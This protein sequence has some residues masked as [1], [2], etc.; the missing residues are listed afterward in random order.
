MIRLF[1]KLIIYKLQYYLKFP[2]ALPVSYTFSI[3]NRCN[4]R[5]KTC[6]VYK[7]S[8]EQMSSQEYAEIFKSIG[9]SPFWVTIS[10]GEPFLRKDLPEIIS[11]LYRHCHPNV[12]NI[13]SNGILTQRI[14]QMVKQITQR[15]PDVQ[16]VINLSIDGIGDQ[17]DSIR[18]VPDNYEKVLATYRGL[19]RLKAT[20]LIVGIHTVI[21]RYNVEDFPAIAD[22]LLALS[23]DS[24][25]TEIAEERKEL[26]TIG[27]NI[28][29]TPL[30]YR[31]AIDFLLH[32]IRNR[33]FYGM[34]RIT[35]AFRI[36]Y[37][38]LV[39]KVLRD[40]KQ[41]I[42]CYAGIASC[43]I[44]PNGDVWFCCVRAES[45]G[46]LR[47]NKYNFKK[48]W[49]SKAANIHRRSVRKKEC[50]CPLANAAYTNMLLNFPTLIRVFIR[51]FIKW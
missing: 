13:P 29:P 36:E 4:S 40:K 12:I 43:Q 45:V 16:I 3:T 21:S 25:I 5:C 51:S 37:Y 39:K 42:P 44:S 23:P 22:G 6:N 26:D 7:Q 11:L 32:R 34:N 47:Q 18:N 2:R 15:C 8:H 41:I 24:Y 38:N 48:I 49:Y 50:Y 46:N 9:K 10:G 35:Q 31:S 1:L 30:E 14:I 27:L 17:H 20:N 33:K 19:K 28:T